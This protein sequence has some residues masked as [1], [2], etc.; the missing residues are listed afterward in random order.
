MIQTRR[1][2]MKRRFWE[3]S[4]K[5]ISNTWQAIEGYPKYLWQAMHGIR[6]RLARGLVAAPLPSSLEISDA[7]PLSAFVNHGRWLVLCPCGSGV[8]VEP[9]E[10][11]VYCASCRNRAD[12]GKVRRVVFPD[13][14]A[15]IE[16]LLKERPVEKNRN[17]KPKESADRLREENRRYL[18]KGGE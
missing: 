10:P 2:S 9:D 17:W 16:G 7:P 18:L 8:L 5:K 11:L 6:Q 12:K 3:Y 15:E 13:G 1:F 4:M 14:V